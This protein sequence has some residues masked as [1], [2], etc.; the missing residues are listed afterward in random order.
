MTVSSLGGGV[1]QP[2]EIQEVGVVVVTDPGK[3][4]YRR[5]DVGILFKTVVQAVLIFGLEEWVVIPDIG[6]MMEGLHY[7][8]ACCLTGN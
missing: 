6:R 5:V 4:G 7:R 3:R 2:I 8:V 1:G